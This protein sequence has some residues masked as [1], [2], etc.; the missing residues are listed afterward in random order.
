MLHALRC[1][2]SVTGGTQDTKGGH[3]LPQPGRSQQRPGCSW[4]PGGSRAH[5]Q[6]KPVG[7]GFCCPAW[8]PGTQGQQGSCAR[9]GKGVRTE[10]AVQPGWFAAP[11]SL[12]RWP[13]PAPSPLSASIPRRALLPHTT[14]MHKKNE[15]T[16]QLTPLY[17]QSRNQDPVL[18]KTG[19]RKADRE[20]RRH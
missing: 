16:Y 20:G 2:L 15:K 18:P 10:P 8:R 14:G 17:Q 1:R 19:G 4:C 7:R 12:P 13:G 9:N 3:C 6:Q 5:A 11:P